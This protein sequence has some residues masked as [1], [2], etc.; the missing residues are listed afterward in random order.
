MET[1]RAFSRRAIVA[2]FRVS[3][4]A[5]FA[6]SLALGPPAAASADPIPS[7]S[8]SSVQPKPHAVAPLGH[9]PPAAARHA[10]A[11]PII[12]PATASIGPPPLARPPLS[13]ETDLLPV[14]ATPAGGGAAAAPP[15]AGK[16][17]GS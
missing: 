4:A 13:L 9:A 17:S 16:A 12:P 6:G 7:R 10:A 11:A 3:A 15:P 1:P 14:G 5:A 2:C 8:L